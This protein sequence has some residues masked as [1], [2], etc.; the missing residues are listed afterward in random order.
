MIKRLYSL[1]KKYCWGL[2]GLLTLC[3]FTQAWGFVPS[4]PTYVIWALLVYAIS[5][6]FNTGKYNKIAIWFLAM[7]PLGILAFNPDPCFKSWMRYGNFLMMFFAVGPLFNGEHANRLRLQ[8]L[9]TLLFLCIFTGV[10]SFFCFFLGINYMIMFGAGD[11]FRE[12]AGLF[13]GL[14]VHSMTLGPI[15]ALGCVALFYCYMRNQKKTYLWLLACCFGA[16][17]FSASRSSLLA[18]LAGVMGCAYFVSEKRSRIVNRI[19][20]LCL[21]AAVTYPIWNQATYLMRSK[22]ANNTEAGSLTSSRDDKFSYRMQEFKENPLFG[23]GFCAID[24]NTGDVYSVS[25]GQ[26]EPGTAWLQV[27]S[28][29]GLAGTIPFVLLLVFAWRNSRRQLHYAQRGLLMGLLSAFFLHFFTEGYLFS[30]GGEVC[31][32][33]WLV[34]ACCSMP[35]QQYV[36]KDGNMV[37][38]DEI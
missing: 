31:M 18:A 27:P 16:V 34:I 29:T 25:T 22:Q 14:C 2:G 9:S 21:L 35:W 11:L 4:V 15:A 20:S 30:A 19:I 6:N 37:V 24:P 28:M 32:F 12:S 36:N 8:A 5:R 23:V 38:L 10:V 3:F 26:I 1:I 17:L 13:G 33:A 7:C